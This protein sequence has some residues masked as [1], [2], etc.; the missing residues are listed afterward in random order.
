MTATAATATA[1][2]TTTTTTSTPST[3]TATILGLSGRH[4]GQTVRYQY[5]GRRQD[6]ANSYCK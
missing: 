1:A 4:T 3:A 2:A 6:R 5:G